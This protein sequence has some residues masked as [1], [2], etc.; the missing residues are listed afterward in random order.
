[1][2]RAMATKRNHA[3]GD[4]A[5][6]PP[7][8]FAEQT[9]AID[10]PSDPMAIRL[11][12]QRAGERAPLR[13]RAGTLVAPVQ[14]GLVEVDVGGQRVIVDKASWLVVPRG[15]RAVVVA[16]SPTAH[17]VALGLSD[18]LVEKTIRAYSGEIEPERF[19]RYLGS[20]QLLPRTNWVNELCHRYL[21]ERAVCKKRD[22]DATRFLETEIAKEAYFVC[23]DR[24]A[25]LT[26]PAF[27]EKQSPLVA[28]AMRYVGDH[29]FEPD[30][31]ARLAKAC[32]ASPST[33]LRAFKRELGQAPLAFVRQRRLDESVLLLKAKELSIGE[34]ATLVGYRN[35][36]AFSQAF[37]ARF[38]VRPSEVRAGALDAGAAGGGHAQS[39]AALASV[40]TG[41]DGPRA[42][43]R[44][45]RRSR[46]PSPR[47]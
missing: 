42:S 22:N 27:I 43:R 5:V 10:D 21:F 18:A 39:R 28:R 2:H 44:T 17:T 8:T 46:A 47:P 45:R 15:A 7:S 31:V 25:S 26:R 23:K 3:R 34:I 14:D 37:R 4:G 1:M 32:G 20:V 19:A 11:V 33:L 41:A 13:F 16:K 29:L 38:G 30:V 12:V 35:F 40:A 6:E 9:S 36:A 24:D